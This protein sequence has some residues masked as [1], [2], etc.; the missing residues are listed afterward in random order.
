MKY[1]EVKEAPGVV[2]IPHLNTV[3]ALSL[4]F[5]QNLQMS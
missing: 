5:I 1:G 3:A 4:A 2:L